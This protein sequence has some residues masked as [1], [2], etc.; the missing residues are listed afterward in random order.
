MSPSSSLTTSSRCNLQPRVCH[1]R[2]NPKLVLIGAREVVWRENHQ[3]LSRW[4]NQ[5]LWRWQMS[6]QT[7]QGCACARAYRTPL[8]GSSEHRQGS[9]E[10]FASKLLFQVTLAKLSHF[11]NR[12]VCW[13]L[14]LQETDV[15]P[16][17]SK[18]LADCPYL[19]FKAL[20]KCPPFHGSRSSWETKTRSAR[21]WMG[22]REVMG[23][24]NC[25]S[26]EE[27]VVAKLQGDKSAS[28]S[29]MELCDPWISGPLCISW[30]FF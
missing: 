21:C 14:R 2:C 1:L 15:M 12:S 17:N 29:S 9:T 24:Q 8:K 23:R 26:L 30:V 6:W 7:H 16:P 10:P 5:T 4:R 25:F 20:R 27:W 19:V 11:Q 3:G 13:T 28:Q 18:S 22:V